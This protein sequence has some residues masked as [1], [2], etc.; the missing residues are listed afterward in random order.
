M[1]PLVCCG[2]LLSARVCLSEPLLR[3]PSSLQLHQV[4]AWGCF[5][6]FNRISIEVRN[7]RHQSPTLSCERQLPPMPRGQEARTAPQ[8]SCTIQAGHAQ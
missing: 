8:Y 1:H 2:V 4:G 5:D 7:C 6:E 3:L